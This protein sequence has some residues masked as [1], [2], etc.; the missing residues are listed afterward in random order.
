MRAAYAF[1]DKVKTDQTSTPTERDVA[2]GAFMFAIRQDLLRRAP[3]KH[4][5]LKPAEFQILHVS[6]P[7]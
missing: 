4:S 2:A 7:G 6:R 1:L 3:L 5:T